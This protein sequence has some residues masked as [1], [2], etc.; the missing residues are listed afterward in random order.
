MAFLQGISK[1]AKIVLMKG[2]EEGKLK[3]NGLL[4][5]VF[6]ILCREL[7]TALCS[8]S[9]SIPPRCPLLVF[10]KVPLYNNLKML[11]HYQQGQSY[12]HLLLAV[13][14]PASE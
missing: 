1:L 3:V 8:L 9:V 5:T 13:L 2:M 10:S 6:C 11:N 14:S 4:C 7:I 12:H